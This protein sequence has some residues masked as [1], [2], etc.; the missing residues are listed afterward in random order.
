VTAAASESN[1]SCIC[2]AV[3]TTNPVDLLVAGNI[4]QSSTNGAGSGFTQRLL[5]NPDGDIAEDRLVT[6]CGFYSASAPLD[7]GFLWVMQ[8]VAFR[9]TG[10]PPPDTTPPAVSIRSSAVGATA[11][12]TVIVTVSASDGGTG[13]AGVQLQVDGVR[14]GA[15][16][17]KSPYTFSL[18]TAHFANGPHSLS[19]SAQDFANNTGTSSPISVTFSNGSPGNPA[20]SGVWSGA[21]SLPIVAVNSVLLPSGKVLLYDGQTSF[22]FDAVVWNPTASV[23]NTVGAP[24]NIFCSGHQ[25][26]A[27][28]RILV[29][30]GHIATHEGLTFAGAFDPH[31]LT[32]I[33]RPGLRSPQPTSSI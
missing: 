29:V 32:Q 17:S 18:N 14:F 26:M 21:V 30:G 19:A 24:A 28:G 9:A 20:Q 31:T 13:V 23:I 3:P 7:F 15:G 12:G 10:S 27:D 8:M 4:V 5:T 2:G 1:T 33:R 22:G 6:T 16:S 11:T 25:Q